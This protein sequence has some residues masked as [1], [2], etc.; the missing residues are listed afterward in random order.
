M[1]ALKSELSNPLLLLRWMA[2][3]LSVISVVL[4]LTFFVGEGFNPANIA[5]KEWL[6]LLFFPVGVVAGLVIAWR[7]EVLGGAIT[8]GSL[9]AFYLLYGLL[10]SGRFPGGWAFVVFAFPGFLFLSYGLLA[11]DAK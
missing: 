1:N 3:F 10:L 5:A 7:R 11:R 8:V 9:L 4:I 6:G 2:R